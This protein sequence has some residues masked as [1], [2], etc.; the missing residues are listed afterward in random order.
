MCTYMHTISYIYF[1]V[2][3]VTVLVFSPNV[4]TIA[5]I[6]WYVAPWISILNALN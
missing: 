2:T 1:H 5:T 6:E 3:I 4:H